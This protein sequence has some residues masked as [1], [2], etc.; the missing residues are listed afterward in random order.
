MRSAKCWAAL[1]LS[2]A[3]AA[4]GCVSLPPGAVVAKRPSLAFAHPEQTRVGAK[5]DSE[6]RAH[7]QKSGFRMLSV[8]ADAFAAR[9]QMVAAAE[10]TLDVQYYIFAADTTGLLLTGALLGAADRG[11]HVRALV[12]DGETS[13]GDE[14]ILALAAHPQIEVRVF[15]PFAFRGHLRV[16]RALEFLFESQRLD[17]RMHNKLFVADNATALIGG[18]NIGDAYFQVD[19]QAQYADD[20]V[21]VGGPLVRKLSAMFDEYWNSPLAVPS[22]ALVGS[23]PSEAKLA[24][25]RKRLDAHLDKARQAGADFLKRAEHGDPFAGI[26][27]GRLP[28]V[29]SEAQLLYDSPDKKPVVNGDAHGRLMYG[30]IADAVKAVTSELIMVTPYLV[31]TAEEMRLLHGLRQRNVRVRIL[32]NSLNSTNELTAHAGYSHNRKQLLREGVELYELRAAL[33][34]SRGSGQSAA[35]SRY[36]NY[37]LHA[38]LLVF[39]RQKLFAGSLNFDQRSK[40]LNTEAG[41]II[42]SPDLAAQTAARFAAMTEPANAYAVSLRSPDSAD[43]PLIWRTQE[44]GKSV[45]YDREPSRSAWRRLAVRAFSALPLDKEL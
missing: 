35:M 44:R 37:G 21:F 41:L 24:R 18:R 2:L 43:S 32:T 1:A 7:P 42:D 11:V 25:Q 36:G 4:A 15:N 34:N 22:Q 6:A 26:I 38:K 33:G 27:A 28:L 20:D 9:M 19:P 8:G 29:W 14:Q 5:F 13:H 40:R 3:M 31:P 30:P 12:D 16:L 39:D 17:Y 45:E 10:R 23:R